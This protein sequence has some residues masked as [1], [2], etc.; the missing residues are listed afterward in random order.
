ML[1]SDSAAARARGNVIDD[2]AME[3]EDPASSGPP[4]LLLQHQLDLVAVRILD[5]GESE[6]FP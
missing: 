2:F 6:A 5:H 1:R 4:L 3:G